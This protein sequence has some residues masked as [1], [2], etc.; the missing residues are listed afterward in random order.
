MPSCPPP[1]SFT[2]T[3]APIASAPLLVHARTYNKQK[4]AQFPRADD[5]AAAL[6]TALISSLSLLSSLE[7]EEEEE[8]KTDT[9]FV[10]PPSIS[11]AVHFLERGIRRAEAAAAP[12]AAVGAEGERRSGRGDCGSGCHGPPPP[13]APPA[14]EEEKARVRSSKFLGWTS[15]K[16]REEEESEKEKKCSGDRA[17]VTVGTGST[18]FPSCTRSRRLF[19]SPTGAPVFRTCKGALG[20]RKRSGKEEAR[21]SPPSVRSLRRR[22]VPR[23]RL[24]YGR[25]AHFTKLPKKASFSPS[26]FLWAS[27]LEE[28]GSAHPLL[29]HP[30]QERHG[31]R[32]S[33]AKRRRRR[34]N[35]K[36][37]VVAWRLSPPP[38]GR[39]ERRE[40]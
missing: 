36:E 38:D 17:T 33:W 9:F 29:L 32:K 7:E 22:R 11:S 27:A 10:A 39:D 3:H 23:I 13:P 37:A 24:R 25:P 16:K 19:P 35:K 1:L 28:T 34:K 8:K 20:E 15:K 4:Q 40:L 30:S 26:F 2:Y 31:G 14:N 18:P 5:V 6:P 12:E 21:I